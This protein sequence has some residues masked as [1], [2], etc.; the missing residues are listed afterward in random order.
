MLSCAAW[1]S[2]VEQPRLPFF[3]GGICMPEVT[4]ETIKQVCCFSYARQGS[5]GGAVRFM[6][7]LSLWMQVNFPGNDW[8][9]LAASG[10]TLLRT[11]S[12]SFAR[13]VGLCAHAYAV[14][15]RD[16]PTM[17]SMMEAAGRIR[18]AADRRLKIVG[19]RL[20]GAYVAGLNLRSPICYAKQHPRGPKPVHAGLFFQDRLTFPTAYWLAAAMNASCRT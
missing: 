10:S 2:S 3:Y 4:R 9:H 1:L 16:V 19:T 5:S 14:R 8:E 17:R 18:T 12:T 11:P 7:S 13:V 6:S 20:G 15:R